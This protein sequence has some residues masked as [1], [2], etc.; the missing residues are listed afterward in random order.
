[1]TRRD[2]LERVLES[3][4]Q[5]IGDGEK[6]AGA[7]SVLATRQASA[8]ANAAKAKAKVGKTGVGDGG[9]H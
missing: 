6:A 8:A 4:R 9:L 3:I 1:M 5:I 7:S 2:E